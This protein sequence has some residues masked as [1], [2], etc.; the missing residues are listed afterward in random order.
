MYFKI[1]VGSYLIPGPLLGFEEEL[2]YLSITG[3]V[4]D[5][6]HAAVLGQPF[7][8]NYFTILD[9]E[10]MKIGLGAHLGSDAE[11]SDEMFNDMTF[12][13]WMLASAIFIMLGIFIY[14][15]FK[16]V[17]EKYKLSRKTS[18]VEDLGDDLVRTN[19]K[20][21][22]E[23]NYEKKTLRQKLSGK[24]SYLPQ[25]KMNDIDDDNSLLDPTDNILDQ[26]FTLN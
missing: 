26:K 2:C 15:C 10:N 19:S 22:Q 17:Q 24:T 23:Q 20:D 6:I 3:S 13:T 5:D 18:S 7:L 4:P 8:E 21:L 9:Q 25:A 16:C 14:M 11:I 12:S 1:P